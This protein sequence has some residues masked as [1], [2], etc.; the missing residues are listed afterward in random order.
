MLLKDAKATA[1]GCL[2]SKTCGNSGVNLW[3]EEIEDCNL[4]II[5]PALFQVHIF[6]QINMGSFG[7]I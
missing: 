2:I 5:V 6:P 3:L 7:K 1:S 4:E